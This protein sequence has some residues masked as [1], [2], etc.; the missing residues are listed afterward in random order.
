VVGIADLVCGRLGSPIS[1][2][3]NFWSISRFTSSLSGSL[4]VDERLRWFA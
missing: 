2:L 1:R 4:W 3:L